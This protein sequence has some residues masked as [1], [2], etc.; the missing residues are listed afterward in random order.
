MAGPGLSPTGRSNPGWIFLGRSPFVNFCDNAEKRLPRQWLALFS[1]TGAAVYQ[2]VTSSTATAATLTYRSAH[3]DVQLWPPGR[4]SAGGSNNSGRNAALVSSRITPAGARQ[5]LSQ[6][7]TATSPTGPSVLAH[8]GKKRRIYFRA[9][10]ASPGRF[11]FYNANLSVVAPITADFTVNADPAEGM[12]TFYVSNIAN[13]APDQLKS[14]SLVFNGQESP[15]KLFNAPY[16][17][18][19]ATSL[20]M[21]NTPYT[22]KARF[23]NQS[24]AVVGEDGAVQFAVNPVTNLLLNPGFE[25]PNS[26]WD[27]GAG[28][29]G[30]K[31]VR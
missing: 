10:G 5:S 8:K 25:A 13:I 15:S 6:R 12:V 23:R 7:P 17:A 3:R 1:S 4:K 20:F 24:D 16:L 31:A 14:I 9:T 30:V 22:A 19:Y 27:A 2:E 28:A 18:M 29:Y 11:S 21:P 26:V